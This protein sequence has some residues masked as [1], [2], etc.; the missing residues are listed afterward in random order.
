MMHLRTVPRGSHDLR[1]WLVPGL[2]YQPWDYAKNT[3]CIGASVTSAESS[4]NHDENRYNQWLNM[5]FWELET[6]FGFVYFLS[7]LTELIR[8]S[9]LYSLS[10]IVR[11]KFQLNWIN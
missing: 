11:R 10:G 2:S 4:W 7:V 9:V 8:W 6:Q 3:R 5:K 1:A